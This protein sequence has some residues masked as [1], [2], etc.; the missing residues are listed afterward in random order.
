MKSIKKETGSEVLDFINLGVGGGQK[1]YTI[2]TK[3]LQM[4]G[5]R[6]L[7]YIPLDESYS[8]LRSA[9]EYVW[10]LHI[11]GS[12]RN[13]ETIAILGDLTR[14]ERYRSLIHNHGS[15]ASNPKIFALLGSVIGNF[16]ERLVLSSVRGSMSDSDVFI[17]GADLIAGRSIEELKKGYSTE[18]VRDL[19]ISPIGEHLSYYR[20]RKEVRTFLSR[21]DEA[22]IGVEVQSNKGDVPGSKRVQ[23]YL[24]IPRFPRL[25]HAFSTKYDL[26]GLTEFLTK[27]M[28][29]RIVDNPYTIPDKRTKKVRYVKFILAKG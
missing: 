22:T 29:F 19:I 3:I 26:G 21:L 10:Q 28:G 11:T 20:K 2:L 5:G 14:L 8:M 24:T 17:L 23:V 4:A 13:W 1:D 12:Y 15:R 7:R 25:N 9:V 16:D 6:R 18:P 27:T